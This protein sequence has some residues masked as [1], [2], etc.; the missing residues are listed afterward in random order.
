MQTAIEA[1][2]RMRADVFKRLD[3]DKDGVFV[4]VC[5]C[6]DVCVCVRVYTCASVDFLLLGGDRVAGRKMHVGRCMWLQ[7]GRCM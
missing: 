1:S 4:Y 5:V 3:L 6:V 2:D 7:V